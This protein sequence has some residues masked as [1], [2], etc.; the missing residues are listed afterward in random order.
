M[1]F[2]AGL[3]NSSGIV[4]NPPAD[5]I[6]LSLGGP[7]FSTAAQTAVNAVRAAGV[8][9]IAAAGNEATSRLL[10][11]ASY[12]GVVSVSAVGANRLRAPYS[13]FGMA[14]D[15]AAP[16]GNLATDINGDGYADGVLSPHADDSFGTLD[17]EYLFLA[18]TSMAAPHVAG[19]V[20]LMKSANAGL[21]PALFDQLLAQGELTDDIGEPG[22]DDFY[23]HGLIDAQK[24]VAAALA[25]AGAPAPDNPLLAATPLSLNFGATTS[26]LEVELSNAGSGA[27]QITAT[28]ST[29]SWLRVN[30]LA[31]D[32]DA[33]GTYVATVDR[34]G[35][36]DGVYTATLS[37]DSSLNSVQV[38]VIMSVGSG[39]F[40]GNVGHVYIVVV[41]PSTGETV[42]G[43]ETDFASGN[44]PYLMS[45]VPAAEYLIVAGTD[46]DNDGF[47]CDEGEVCGEYLT[48]DQPIVV[49]VDREL[50]GL[51]FLVN[52]AAPITALGAAGTDAAGD[53]RA[54]PRTPAKRIP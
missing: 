28:S 31:V 52:Y 47:I 26:A 16:G 24:A 11:P 43:T 30:P 41:D 51:D 45:G 32:G 54:V 7:G 14:I 34:A 49:T 37:F 39:G 25:A 44:F 42:L 48:R 21:T 19:V 20:A 35:L 4:A 50:S 33:L 13:N 15:V 10:Y 46:Y 22:R 36:A 12:S 1:R 53:S 38:P 2:A 8:V 3:R 27:L 6:N 18:G 9:V 5:V 23:G 17:F 29:E 40:G